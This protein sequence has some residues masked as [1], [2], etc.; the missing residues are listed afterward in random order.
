MT[1]MCFRNYINLQI[2]AEA[3]SRANLFAHRH[4]PQTSGGLGLTDGGVAVPACKPKGL[5]R[6]DATVFLPQANI[7]SREQS[8]FICSDSV[9]FAKTRRRPLI[10]K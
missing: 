9:P 4:C 3:E 8:K 2:Y 5:L 10:R 1:T 7:R 6:R